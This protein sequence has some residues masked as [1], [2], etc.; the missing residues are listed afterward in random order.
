MT[1]F[2]ETTIVSVDRT[3]SELQ[4]ILVKHGATA[5]MS[6]YEA[7][8]VT[9]VSFKC[10]TPGGDTPVRLPCKWEQIVALLRKEGRMP[11]RGDT[12]ETWGR[13]VAWRTVFHWVRAQMAFVAAEQVR[14][15][16]VFLPYMQVGPEG[17]TA[18]Q[19]LA[20]REFKM[21]AGPLS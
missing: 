17:Q 12:W 8:Q 19:M 3:L 18:Y 15:D 14:L 10:P 20:A 21:L 16:E 2:M 11:K 4:T 9:H 7:G 5:I 6:E 13:R 1:L